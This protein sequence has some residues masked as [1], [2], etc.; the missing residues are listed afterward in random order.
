MNIWIL[1][2]YATNQ[3][4]DGT[5]R[6][7]AFA[8]YLVR[9]GHNVK[10]FCANTVHNSNEIVNLEG[11]RYIEKT[12]RDNVSYVFV[13]TRSYHRNG[14]KRVMNMIDYY[15][16]VIVALN[17]YILKEGRPSILLAS[18]VHPLTL[19]AGIRWGRKENVKCICEIRDLW[20][21]SIVAY[22]VVGE[23][24]LVIKCLRRLEKWIYKNSDFII[25]TMGGGYDYIIDQGWDNE[26]PRSKVEQINNG[27]D[28]ELYEYNK[29]KYF[30]VDEDLENP[31]TYK[32]VYTGSLRKANEQIYALFDAIKLMQGEQFKN[33]RFFIYGRGDLEDSLKKICFEN[34]YS[35]VKIKGFVDK[36]YIPYI[37]SKCDLNILNCVSHSILRYG[38]SQN[39]L[40]DY[41]AS[42]NPIISGEDSKY[43]VVSLYNCGI[44]KDFKNSNE[45]VSAIEE[46]KR[47]PISSKHISEVAK[48]YDFKNLT[49]KLLK[50][51][52]MIN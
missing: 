9:M 43:S 46:L 24:N 3:Y 10:I 16:N 13:K 21:E 44:A 32:I 15:K 27:I 19:V 33:Y 39:K 28:L 25:F 40:F 2:H 45:L 38:G 6:H 41:L 35:N 12:G 36:K 8:K 50:I 5:G 31:D 42:G 34:N 20:P 47:H 48:K 4:F 26:I 51:I 7:Q 52:N 1:N 18:S 37:L 17:E 29:K 11:S 49:D 14:F 22:G 30:L 23:K